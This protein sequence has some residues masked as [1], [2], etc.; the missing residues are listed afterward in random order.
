M[1]EMITVA[2]AVPPS[3]RSF[4]RGRSF[5]IFRKSSQARFPRVDCRFRRAT[6]SRIPCRR[7]ICTF[8]SSYSTTGRTRLHSQFCQP[9]DAPRAWAESCW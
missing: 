6:F 9:F 4:A 5:L 7:P 3:M 1:T 8:S 2:S